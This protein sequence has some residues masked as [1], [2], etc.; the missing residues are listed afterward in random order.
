MASWLVGTFLPKGFLQ[1]NHQ[2]EVGREGF[3][4][5]AKILSNFFKRELVKYI[6][7]ELDPLGKKIIECC[8]NDGTLDDYINLIPMKL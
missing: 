6:T 5:G 7:P 1:V 2:P 3:E 4:A 8:M